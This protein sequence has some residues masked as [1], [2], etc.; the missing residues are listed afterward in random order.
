MSQKRKI[1]VPMLRV[2]SP[3]GVELASPPDEIVIKFGDKLPPAK[4][5]LSTYPFVINPEER[6]KRKLKRVVNDDS[7]LQQQSSS[8]EN[9]DQENNQQTSSQS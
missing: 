7:E 9:T 5:K 1:A 4:Y 6:I 8:G 2:P 3:P